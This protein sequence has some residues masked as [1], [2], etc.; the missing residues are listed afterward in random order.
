MYNYIIYYIII[1]YRYIQYTYYANSL[2]FTYF[3]RCIIYFI[4]YYYKC[5]FKCSR[6]IT[7]CG[8]AMYIPIT[9]Q[10]S[11]NNFFPCLILSA[12]SEILKKNTAIWYCIYHVARGSKGGTWTRG[13]HCTDVHEKG[14]LKGDTFGGFTL[15]A[16]RNSIVNMKEGR[17]VS[18]YV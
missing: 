6:C 9:I 1:L 2:S 13:T 14:Q 18:K 15:H 12:T 3:I 7:T 5:T 8:V 16:Q 10:L 11:K 4:Q 17:E